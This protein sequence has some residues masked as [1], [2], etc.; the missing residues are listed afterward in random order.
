MT[1]SAYAYSGCRELGHLWAQVQYGTKGKVVPRDLTC[2]ECGTQ[3]FD[4]IEK[5][6]GDIIRR[7]Y[8]YPSGY[9]LGGGEGRPS[10]SY[11]RKQV[12]EKALRQLANRG[13]R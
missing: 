6:S 4:E 12:V 1:T 11:F 9:L 7:S 3:R 13:K 5:S 8:R 10:S 2:S